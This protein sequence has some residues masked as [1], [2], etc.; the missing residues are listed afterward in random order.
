[1][2]PLADRSYY[3]SIYYN[4][5]CIF[6]INGHIC[7]V[8]VLLT[9][10]PIALIVQFAIGLLQGNAEMLSV[11]LIT[12]SYTSRFNSSC[13]SQLKSETSVK[14]NTTTKTKQG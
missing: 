14:Q 3:L 5:L 2:Q 8:F 13:I 4:I 10:V 11:Q 9:Q 1:M 7:W 6:L 12:D